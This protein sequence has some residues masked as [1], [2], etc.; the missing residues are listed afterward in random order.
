[1][2]SVKGV[3]RGKYQ[4]HILTVKGDVYCSECGMK[5]KKRSSLMQHFQA[6]HLKKRIICPQCSK[7]FTSISTMGRHMRRVHKTGTDES[8]TPSSTPSNTTSSTYEHTLPKM[9][10]DPDRASPLFANILSVKESTSFGMHVIAKSDIDADELVMVSNAFASASCL[11]SINS[12]CF[13]CGKTQNEKYNCAHCT[14]VAFCSKRCS[15][16]EIHES[17]CDRIFRQS[18]CYIVRLTVKII[19]NA[20]TLSKNSKALIQFVHDVF[21]KKPYQSCQTPFFTYGEILTL[22]GSSETEQMDGHLKMVNRV[23]ECLFKLPNIKESNTSRHILSNMASRHIS[24]IK[25]NSFS[26][27]FPIQKGVC[28]RYGLHDVLSRINHSCDPNVDHYYDE[29]NAI[30]CVTVRAIKKGEQIFINYLG[31]MKFANTQ[32]RR[33]YIQKQWLFMCE[34]NMCRAPETQILL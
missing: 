33:A 4:S 29:D 20:F 16:S 5:Y 23:V 22:K 6:K 9:A 3:R 15:R 10:F 34:C 7:K 25:I 26:E 19:Q 12:C 32:S 21:E 14:N 2:G 11:N 31:E 28:T 30:R 13:E 8:N 18:D 1:M 17:I 27:E 24:T